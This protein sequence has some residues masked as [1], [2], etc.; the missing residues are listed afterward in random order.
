MV[1]DE[2]PRNAI[3]WVQ[4]NEPLKF[5]RMNGAISKEHEWI[6]LVANLKKHDDCRVG[7]INMETKTG[8]IIYGFFFGLIING[9]FSQLLKS[10]NHI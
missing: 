10:I 5:E 7:F 4:K 2:E 8:K 3:K 9:Y 1:T 6:R